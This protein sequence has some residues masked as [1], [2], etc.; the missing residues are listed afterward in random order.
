MR[1]TKVDLVEHFQQ[2]IDMCRIE[3]DNGSDSAYIIWNYTNLLTYLG[4]EIICTFRQDIYRGT[5]AKFVNTL[6]KV[7]VVHTLEREDNIKLYV[8]KLDNHCT[9]SFRDIAE[10]HTVERV[11]VYVVDV[12]MD[13]SARA[14]W[15]DLTVQDRDRKIATLRL[16]NPEG[17]DS[18]YKGRYIL[19][20]IRR[21]KYGFSTDA[22]VTVDSSFSY[23]P[24]VLVA[25]SFI[26]KTFADDSQA[27]NAMQSMNFIETAKHYVAEEP[28]YLLVRLAMELDI[29]NEMTNLT[30]DVPVSLLRHALLLDK[31]W[32]LNNQ[33]LYHQEIVGFA[34][35]SRARLDDVK[36]VLQVLYSDSEEFAS[37][38]LLV[39]SI[40]HLADNLVTVKKRRV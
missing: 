29:A 1:L 4:E 16:F 36:Q 14:T 23:S 15:W 25:E 10:G 13:S 31:F 34:S 6:A 17:S 39:S 35:A 24:E 5:P 38:R 27:L 7:G 11:T 28:G 2:E 40:K 18:D 12:T 33:S 8:D 3:I 20:N 37:A 9:I 21:N 26:T 32:V 19:C 30:R 22:I